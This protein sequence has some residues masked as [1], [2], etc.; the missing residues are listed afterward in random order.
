MSAA[1]HNDDDALA[2]MEEMFNDIDVE[3]E[4]SADEAYSV[5]ALY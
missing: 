1:A 5:L 2:S 3:V 4:T